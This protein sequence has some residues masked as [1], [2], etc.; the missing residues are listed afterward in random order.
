[1]AVTASLVKL[2][3]LL[4]ATDKMTAVIGSAVKQS[5][6]KLTAFEKS[7]NRIGTNFT[8]TGALMTTAGIG[9]FEGMVN[10]ARQTADYGDS[11]IKTAQKVGIGVEAWQQL[12]YAAKLANVE[13]DALATSM[14]QFNKTLSSAFAGGNKEVANGLKSLGIS[15]MD[16]SGKM[17][18][19]EDILK[20]IADVFSR[21]ED[22]AGKTTIATKLFGKSGAELIPLLNTG[23]ASIEQLA[24][25]ALNLGIVIDE[26]AAKASEEFNGNLTKLQKS[27]Q[28]FTIVLGTA[29]IPKIDQLVQKAIEVAQKVKDWIKENAGLVNTIADAALKVSG[30]LIVTGV[31]T[32]SIGLITS[33]VGKFITVGR[34]LIAVINGAKIAFAAAKSSML[35][36]KIQYYALEVQT[37]ACVA[38]QWLWNGALKA[39]D[40]GMYIAQLALM[41]AKQLALTIAT[42]V[43][44]AA[45]WLWN[46][47]MSANPIGLIILAVVA[48]AAAV[49]LIIKN[50]DKVKE[51]FM[52]L[53]ESVKPIFTAVWEWIKNLFLNYTPYGLIIK[54][55]DKIVDWFKKLWDRVKSAF[56]AAWE[57]IKK[58]FFNYTPHGLIIKHWGSI[59][60]WFSSLWERVKSVFAALNPIEWL[61]KT[62]A[63]VREWFI[64]LNKK[65]F[66]FGRNLMSGLV[67]GIKA[68]IMKPAEIIT[69]L[70]KS[71]KD[72]FTNLLGIKSPSTVFAEY[73]LNI[74]RGLSGGIEQGQ[75]VAASATEGLAMQTVRGAGITN[76]KSTVRSI[77]NTSFGGMTVNYSPTV[78]VSGSSQQDILAALRQHKTEFIRWVDDSMYNRRRIAF[79]D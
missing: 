24:E 22:S 78:N 30:F 5:T 66:N 73:G 15:I 42:K 29:L 61:T 74:T 18:K 1:M 31:L 45:Q 69:E 8:K 50:W 53:W 26:E 79:A 58:I 51:F 17:R 44:A 7:V 67:N 32:T 57:G 20:D 14:I 59:V 16:A 49:Y 36:F 41:K 76:N 21:T 33:V 72:T 10:L 37:K 47:A 56:T 9:I 35:L 55:W 62:F 46:A 40:F 27:V 34:G 13:S 2:G 48:L 38:A 23:A 65:F 64:A 60:S 43:A 71:I 12:A 39:V 11:A 3:F 68:M 75:G 77:E 52:K 6:A 28:G 63:K 25:E 54:H 19:Q 4:A 70:G